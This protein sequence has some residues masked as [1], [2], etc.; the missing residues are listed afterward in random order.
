[1]SNCI[2]TANTCGGCHIEKNDYPFYYS[3]QQ[4][5]NS[6]RSCASHN[7]TISL[8]NSDV[9]VERERFHFFNDSP[10]NFSNQN[11]L[12]FVYEKILQTLPAHTDLRYFAVSILNNTG[13]QL[14]IPHTGIKLTIP[15]DAVLLDEDHLIYVALLTAE[16]QMPTLT[17][18]QT[19]LSPVILIGPSD[20]TLVKPAVLSFEHTAVLDTA[21]KYN[22]MFCDDSKHWRCI[23]TYGQENISTPVHLQFAHDQQA[24]ILF[25]NIGAYALIGESI[26]N[27]QASKYIQMACF[28]GQS[29]LRLRFF[30]KTSDAFEH[31]LNEE[32]AMKSFL[33]DQPKQFIIHD[34]QD[35]I[36]MNVD[37]ELSTMSRINIGYKEIPFASFWTNR[38]ERSCFIFLIPNLQ[39]NQADPDKNC[40]E[41]FTIHVD[42]Y[43]PNIFTSAL[44]TRLLINTHNLQYT[45]GWDATSMR[46]HHF[47]QTS[48]KPSRLPTVIRQKLCQILDPPTTLGNDWRMFASNLLGI[49]YL[50]Y[51]A[52]KTSPTEHLLTLWD[53]RQESFVNMINVLNQIGRSDAACVIIA[54]MNI[55]SAFFI[56]LS[57]MKFQNV[58]L[59]LTNKTSISSIST[60]NYREIM[61]D[62]NPSQDADVTLLCYEIRLLQEND[63][64]FVYFFKNT[65][66][67]GVWH[68]MKVRDG[69]RLVILNG[70]ETLR[71][72]QENVHSILTD[73]T[74]SFTFQ[75][76]W[77]PELYIQL[78]IS[79][80]SNTLISHRSDKTLLNND[81]YDQVVRILRHHLLYRPNRPYKLVEELYRTNMT[82]ETESFLDV[83]KQLAI[84]SNPL[85]VENNTEEILRNMLEIDNFFKII[86]VGLNM[87]REIYWI[88]VSMKM[89]AIENPNIQKLRFW[90]KIFGMRNDY[91]IVEADFH[92]FDEID[93]ND[94]EFITYQSMFSAEEE[95]NMTTNKKIPPE[96]A[97]EGVNEKIIY[98]STGIDQPFVQLPLVTPEQIELSRQ[99]QRFFTGDLEAAVL[100][101]SGFPGVEKHLLR[102]QI[103]RVSAG[104]QI[105]PKDYFRVSI[106]DES[107]EE[108]EESSSEDS[109][110]QNIKFKI[111]DDFKGHTIEN[112]A[113]SSGEYWVHCVPYLYEQGRHIY[114]SQLDGNAKPKTHVHSFSSLNDDIAID[115]CHSAWSIGI[116]STCV[117]T[118]AKAFVRSNRWPGAFTVGDRH[119]FE[120]IYIGWGLKNF[121][122]C[123]QASMINIFPQ[124]EY[125]FDLIEK[126]DPTVE[127]ENALFKS[128]ILLSPDDNE[129]FEDNIE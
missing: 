86:G 18:N 36:C 6:T 113:L 82:D 47:P 90:G 94:S 17:T 35:Q 128:S 20:I 109:N 8:T 80:R 51:F 125:K 129:E 59:S 79:N 120:N 42:V 21:W 61:I 96:L 105:A 107:E 13:C 102:A 1:R 81:I 45:S 127:E 44:H 101:P 106:R 73:K 85:I 77:H 116:T 112:L 71:K 32:T 10:S 93:S 2:P 64:V 91:Y 122:E 92:S 56:L 52:T 88:W 66:P 27:Q 58:S 3:I 119:R 19:R 74:F 126:D 75:V 49:S 98:V 33:C 9:G 63:T 78:E 15:E 38:I 123:S 12:N 37:L 14:K 70:E 62:P 34:N 97:G 53:A 57:T 48:E 104:T 84:L 111:N 115:E 28:Y 4:D 22:L 55:T 41:Q 76:V 89:L 25:E 60:E 117:P 95:T 108:E 67:N 50:Q 87:E 39:P 54:H 7:N 26:L 43:Q 72:T 5:T 30:D 69:D 83:K 40:M 103:Q 121:N 16:N 11:H 68:R 118:Y 31:C 110:V 29:A 124:N 114:Y 99:I 46:P 65:S 100:S 23:L 24:F